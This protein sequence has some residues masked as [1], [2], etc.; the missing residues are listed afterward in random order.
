VSHQAGPKL[1]ARIAA[2]L[3]GLRERGGPPGYTRPP[4]PQRPAPRFSTD[5]A[6]AWQLVGWMLAMQFE[7]AVLTTARDRAQLGA[8]TCAVSNGVIGVKSAGNTAEL[9]IS[10]AMLAILTEVERDHAE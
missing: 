4:A 6:A 2:G 8:W 9:A 7:V 1:D 5:I 3:Q 10:R